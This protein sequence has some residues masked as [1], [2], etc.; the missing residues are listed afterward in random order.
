MYMYMAQ[1]LK[2]S[3]TNPGRDEQ[4]TVLYVPVKDA[5]N[6]VTIE[7]YET[8]TYLEVTCAQIGICAE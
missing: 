7:D 3:G 5:E 4:Y 1:K 8:A 2:I 6:L